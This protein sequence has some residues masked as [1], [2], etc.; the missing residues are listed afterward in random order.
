MVFHEAI[1]LMSLGYQVE[2]WYQIDGQFRAKLID[3]GVK[4]VR[5]A[6]W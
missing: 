3:L 2:V 4:V 6:P 1:H 5:V